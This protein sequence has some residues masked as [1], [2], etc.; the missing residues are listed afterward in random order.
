MNF[1]IIFLCLLIGCLIGFEF[2]KYVTSKKVGE[3]MKV[4]A[5]NLKREAETAQQKR[6]MAQKK[7]N[8]AIDDL[9]KDINEAKKRR[10]QKMIDE[11]YELEPIREE[12]N[13]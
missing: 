2:G 11:I 12:K 9:L 13:K 8:S 10:E 3:I 4:F 5:D 1:W 6:E 7:L